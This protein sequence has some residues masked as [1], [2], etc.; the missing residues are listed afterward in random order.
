MKID[1][2]SDIDCNQ[3]KVQYQSNEDTVEQL[4][5]RNTQN[6]SPRLWVE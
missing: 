5:Y 3:S 2:W 6:F 1:G 4:D